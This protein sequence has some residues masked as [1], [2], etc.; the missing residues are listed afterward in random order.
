MEVRNVLEPSAKK[1]KSSNASTA[2]EINDIIS[3]LPDTILHNILSFLPTDYAVLT[4][5]LSK[6]WRYLWTSISCLDFDHKLF[7][8]PLY[9]QLGDYI[10]PSL[11]ATT[12]T[13]DTFIEFVDT[14][15]MLHDAS[16]IQRF[17]LSCF[18]YSYKSHV[19]TWI[20]VAMMHNVR[21]LD[22][23]IDREEDYDPYV[24]LPGFSS[25][26]PVMFPHTLFTCESLEVL[27][28]NLKWSILKMPA[29]MSFRA[30]KTLDLVE[31][32]FSEDNWMT[33][34]ISSCPILESLS[35]EGCTLYGH[36]NLNIYGHKLRSLN[37]NGCYGL[38]KC[39]IVLS[40]PV[41][42]SFKYMRTSMAQDCSLEN[43]S[44]VVNADIDFIGPSWFEDDDF[45]F[46]E[47][48]GYHLCKI[49]RGL[50]NVKVLKLCAWCIQV[51]DLLECLPIPLF[52]N[53]KYLK[54]MTWFDKDNIKV[55]TRL[56]RSFPVL[57]SLHIHNLE[58]FFV[59]EDCWEAE[60]F[61]LE[62]CMMD[63]LM[64][65]QIELFMGSRNE[66]ELLKFLLNKGRFLQRLILLPPSEASTS[67]YHPKVREQLLAMTA[68]SNNQKIMEQL[69]SYPRASSNVAILL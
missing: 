9:L 3:G 36:Q 10:F 30:L 53:L 20:R 22:F 24:S 42:L 54:L 28:M 19:N 65:V 14:V 43:L 60:K 33:E 59:H 16:N 21:E 61:P 12:A 17:C 58:A 69:L 47:D 15:L 8:S 7:Y 39:K 34:L 48:A 27:K 44:S 56:L 37:I 57:E 62:N 18:Y 41:L 51:P 5:F 4:S 52:N 26:E 40:A 11:L 55:I 35:M 23:C 1:Y 49:L 45:N 25:E 38:M 6:R 29:T 67:S 2:R 64:E 13:N 66:L 63:H 50:S 31:V 32:A 68:C 46:D